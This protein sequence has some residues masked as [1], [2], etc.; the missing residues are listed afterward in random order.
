MED[1]TE[2]GVT[3]LLFVSMF[4]TAVQDLDDTSDDLSLDD[5]E[6]DHSEQTPY[7]RDFMDFIDEATTPYH[8]VDVVRRDLLAAGYEELRERDV[9]IQLLIYNP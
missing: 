3:V 1:E 2:T 7:A 8:A 4:D 6:Y 9:N 5:S